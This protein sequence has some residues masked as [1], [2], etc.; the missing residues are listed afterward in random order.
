[1]EAILAHISGHMRAEQFEV[2]PTAGEGTRWAKKHGVDMV[3][4]RR[5]TSEGLNQRLDES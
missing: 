5:F 1:M 4:M 3:L 2:H